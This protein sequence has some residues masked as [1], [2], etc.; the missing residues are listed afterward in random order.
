MQFGFGGGGNKGLPKGWKKVPSQSRPGEF[1]YLN[2]ETGKRYD[3]L[4]VGNFYDDER[5]TVT[6]PSWN[7]FAKEESDAANYGSVQEAAGFAED[8]GD[9]ANAGGI[10]YLAFVPFLL[11]AAA[12]VFGGVNI[13]GGFYGSSGNF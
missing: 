5:D 7:P 8:G 2:T 4:P 9:L 6:A 1:S 3:R 12:Y 11:F 13:A 10:L